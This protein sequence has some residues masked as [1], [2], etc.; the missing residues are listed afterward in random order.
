MAQRWKR[1]VA[2]DGTQCCFW[3]AA[4]GLMALRWER[5]AAQHAFGG[6][7]VETAQKVLRS[8]LDVLGSSA[9][10]SAA[11][12]RHVQQQVLAQEQK[13][14]ALAFTS[15]DANEAQEGGPSAKACSR[16][17]PQHRDARGQQNHEPASGS[18]EM[19]R[20]CTKP[21]TCRHMSYLFTNSF[22]Q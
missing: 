1:R 13:P 12:R 7:R 15:F 10:K 16:C 20:C 18:C 14:P 22:D 9:T 3:F 21:T 8:A 19:E 2:E 5:R 4:D 11:A 17:F 6:P